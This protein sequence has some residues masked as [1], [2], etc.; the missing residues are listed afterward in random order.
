MSKSRGNVVDP[1]EV[2]DRHGADAFRWY[3]LTSQQP[4]AGYRFSVETVGE[5]VRQFLLTL[6]NTY[7]FLVL[8]ANAEGLDADGLGG[9]AGARA[10]EPLDRWVAL[11]PAG[12]DARG[13]RA[14]GRLRLHHAPGGRSPSTSTSSPTGTCGSTAAASGTATGPPSRPCATAC[15]RSRSCSRRSPLPRRRDLR[16]TSTAADR[17]LGPP[18]RLSR[19]PTPSSS[20]GELE[21]GVEAAL[22]AIELGRAARAQAK[23]KMR[24]PLRAGG[25]RRHRGR[26]A[27]RSS[28]SPSSSA[29]SST[30]RS[31]SSSPRRASSSRYAVKPNYRALGPRF[32]K[33]MPQVAA[34][35]EALDPDHVAEAI[36]GERR[37]GINVDGAD[38]TL[39]PDD[40]D[41]GDG[42]ARGLRG[43]GRGRAARSRW[44]SSSTTSCAARASRARSCTRSR[45]RAS[46]RASRS[47]T[48]SR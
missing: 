24:Q 6:W 25:D 40:I 47:P 9:R 22:R 17:R 15:S 43:R 48:G 5:T 46:R 3:Y 11:A 27:P 7:S 8:Y 29:P 16:A 44:R 28:G 38:H 45:T 14:H 10:D 31:S 26:A 18:R 39:E 1:W 41:P 2:I 21:A 32:G 35:V 33:E 37:I 42:A 36:R 12:A 4:W 30:S 23:V 19:A 34:A 20:D 13:D